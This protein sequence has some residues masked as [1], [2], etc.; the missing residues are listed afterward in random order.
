MTYEVRRA[1]I[2]DLPDIMEI[3]HLAIKESLAIET[4]SLIMDNPNYRVWVCTVN[5][6]EA[7]QI[8]GYSMWQDI[9]STHVISRLLVHPS[10]WRR[11]VG[12]ELVEDTLAD[13][14][15][16][17]NDCDFVCITEQAV[18]GFPYFL[19][20]LGFTL[21]REAGCVN[22]YSFTGDTE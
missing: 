3:E 9:G 8:L 15:K 13:A 18:M 17:G 16:C 14:V 7:E 10:C 5:V 1:T 12:R 20:S 4:V 22:L 6:D 21:N 19:R 11:G 2:N